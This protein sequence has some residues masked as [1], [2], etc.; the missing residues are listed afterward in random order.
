MRMT[1]HI[2]SV[3]RGSVGGIT[4]TAN[5]YYQ[6]ITKARTAPVQPNTTN[7][8]RV[9]GAFSQASTDWLTQI[10]SVRDNWATY[11]ASLVYEGP[12]GQ[13]SVSGRSVFMSNIGLYNYLISRGVT[14]QSGSLLAPTE[15]GFLGIGDVQFDAPTAV[16][17]GFNVSIDNPNTEDVLA[18][19]E[20]SRP[21]DLTRNT[22]KGPFLSSSLV[23]LAINTLD[24]ADVDFTG[25]TLGKVY[26]L[27]LRLI[28]DDGAKR[29][30]HV[31][32][33][34]VEAQ[35]TIS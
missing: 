9:K 4:Y 33:Y 1:S 22:F 19:M 25:L 30:S 21:F 11:A 7:Q 8:S 20:I 18:V 14:F 26:F 24:T 32:Y 35:Q 12:L 10:Q 31:S 3:A 17:I 5:Q 23:T 2:A 29:I 16:G 34:R 27:R 6:I 15:T 28:V 13:Y